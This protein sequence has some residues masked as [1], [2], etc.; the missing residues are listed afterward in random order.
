MVIPWIVIVV[1][2]LGLGITYIGRRL[3]RTSR[4]SKGC[5]IAAWTAVIVFFVLP[6]ASMAL[7]RRSGG[8]LVV[9][10]WITY[11]GLGFLSF[12]FC[13]LLVRDAA[14]QRIRT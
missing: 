5:N 3:I 1:V 6:I 2:A 4:L 10:S 9:L 8:P 13:F 11:V 14:L 7:I 12:I